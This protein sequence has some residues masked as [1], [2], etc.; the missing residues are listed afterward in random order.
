MI[1]SIKAFNQALVP[2]TLCIILLVFN[3]GCMHGKNETLQLS[4]WPLN[5]KWS[6]RKWPSFMIIAHWE[7]HPSLT[8]LSLSSLARAA[9]QGVKAP[10][11]ERSLTK[12]IMHACFGSW[13]P[14]VWNGRVAKKDGIKP[15]WSAKG[16][17][18]QEWV[19]FETPMKG[20]ERV[21]H[22]PRQKDRLHY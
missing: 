4:S 11:G 14:T 19:R 12:S 17:K 9:K 22:F 5:W 1:S 20:R 6:P 7:P 16:G 15:F 13:W 2:T 21:C 18:G 3:H 8:P 10:G